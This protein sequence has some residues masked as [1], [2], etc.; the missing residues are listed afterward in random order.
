MS[1]IQSYVYGVAGGGFG[2]SLWK[3]EDS[4]QTWSEINSFA[5]YIGVPNSVFFI[6]GS[7]HAHKY[8][9]L[10]LFF[11]GSQNPGSPTPGE[12]VI[13]R[14]FDGGISAGIAGGN[15]STVATSDFFQNDTAGSS[16]TI[17]V[18]WSSASNSTIYLIG[19]QYL[20]RSTDGGYTFNYVGLLN[21]ILNTTVGTT[22][23]DSNRDI[24]FANINVGIISISTNVYRTNDAGSTWT[25]LLNLP[26]TDPISSAI[27]DETGLIINLLTQV[28][29][30][31]T[32]Y[33]SVDGGVTWNAGTVLTT[34]GTA[35]RFN[36][37]LDDPETLFI[38][39]NH[40]LA[41]YNINKSTDFGSTWTTITSLNLAHNRFFNN[42]CSSTGVG[43]GLSL[44]LTTDNGGI[45][46][47]QTGIAQQRYW[48]STA[49]SYDCGCP[50]DSLLY[51]GQCIT[52]PP[53]CFPNSIINNIGQINCECYF[54]DPIPCCFDLTPCTGSGNIIHTDT[55][56]T[57]GI[58]EY[59]G[60]IIRIEGSEECYEVT[61]TE[62]ACQTGSVAVV[63]E[64]SYTDCF[65]C[66]PVYM[67]TAC[68]DDLPPDV[69]SPIFTD[70]AIFGNYIGQVIWLDAGNNP[71]WTTCYF[72][73]IGPYDADLT[74]LPGIEETF[75]SC[76]SCG[77][78][79][80]TN[81]TN[82]GDILYSL[83]TTLSTYVGQVGKYN[84]NC[85]SVTFIQGYI[86]ESFIDNPFIEN[87]YEDCECCTYIPPEPEFV[88]Y[89]RVIPEPVREFYRIAQSK[90]EI[91]TNIKYGVGW[92]SEFMRLKQG[93]HMC[94]DVDLDKLWMK[95]KLQEFSMIYDESLCQ[96][97]TTPD[98]P[99]DCIEPTGWTPFG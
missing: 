31:T 74:I 41:S 49:V 5:P 4:G 67:L 58:D 14:S 84:D 63:I 46:Y 8:N 91:D 30:I 11:A 65:N 80:L 38:E 79:R 36:P 68:D 75:T 56:L 22:A 6:Y 21:N 72:V 99:P 52:G 86:S 76:D 20:Y 53:C 42:D 87:P 16:G 70:Q 81:C 96:P 97:A 51:E 55:I 90:C 95:Y 3:T 69:E 33:K 39:S 66:N 2:A 60:Q 64:A 26:T 24:F 10:K 57:P 7:I 18:R 15:W 32:V 92:Y 77:Y 27:I 35:I 73:G 37:C 93:I 29:S 23:P 82:P 13:V 54:S 1:L 88:K 47:T 78:Y 43:Y 34:A 61:V 50:P 98:T 45:A 85:Y 48:H 62:S 71:K 17:R 12:S 59:E 44:L 40:L 83:D 89:E 94:V 25:P 28:G 19:Q 9:R